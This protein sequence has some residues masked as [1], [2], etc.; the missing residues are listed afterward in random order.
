MH[1]VTLDMAAEWVTHIVLSLITYP[2]QFL[3]DEDALRRY[4]RLLVVPSIVKGND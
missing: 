2:G 1:R 4:L 3:E